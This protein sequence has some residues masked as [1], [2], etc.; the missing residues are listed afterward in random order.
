MF[1][2]EQG[3]AAENEVD[4]DDGGSWHWVVYALPEGS[5]HG[6]NGDGD[7]GEDRGDG[8][9][10]AIGVIRLVPPT[11]TTTAHHPDNANADT[12]ADA[13]TS[14]SGNSEPHIKLARLAVLPPTAATT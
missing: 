1:V 11:G 2:E 4:G 10:E 13:T 8:N 7:G 5:A 9:G 6:E 3:C 14:A 12:T